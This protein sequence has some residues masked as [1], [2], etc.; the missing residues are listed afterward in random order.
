MSDL[1]TGTHLQPDNLGGKNIKK[2]L[3]RFSEWAETVKYH[4]LSSEMQKCTHQ[5]RDRKVEPVMKEL[6]YKVRRPISSNTK[7]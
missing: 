1:I 2:E 3:D 5:E 4:S 6:G 7:C